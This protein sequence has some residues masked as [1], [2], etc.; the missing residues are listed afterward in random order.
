MK[1]I[2]ALLFITATLFSNEEDFYKPYLNVSP[3][4]LFM[5][6]MSGALNKVLCV[7]PSLD[8]K[9]AL[10]SKTLPKWQHSKPHM[11]KCPAGYYTMRKK[12]YMKESMKR[13]S[14]SLIGEKI[15]LGFGFFPT[16]PTGFELFSRDWYYRNGYDFFHIYTPLYFLFFHPNEQ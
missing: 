5:F 15:N 3:N 4:M 2:I 10:N 14:A 9:E 8:I 12:R 1:K 7:N 16:D 13:V 11:I 6:S